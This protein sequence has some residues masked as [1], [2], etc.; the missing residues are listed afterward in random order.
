[1][2]AVVDLD[3]SERAMLNEAL[4]RARKLV[5]ELEEQK[6]QVDASPPA[7]DPQKLEEGRHAMI[8]AIASARRMLAAL[9]DAERIADAPDEEPDKNT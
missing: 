4:T 3:P 5:K 9:E 1:M 7:I 6:K 8:K 2:P